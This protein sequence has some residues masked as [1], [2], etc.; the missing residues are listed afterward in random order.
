LKQKLND[1]MIKYEKQTHDNLEAN[2]SIESLQY[3]N[4]SLQEEVKHYKVRLI[5]FFSFFLF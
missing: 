1:L 2:F 4:Q 3:L 5:F